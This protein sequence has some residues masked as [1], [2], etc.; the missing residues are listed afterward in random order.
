MASHVRFE[1]FDARAVLARFLL[2]LFGGLFRFVVIEDDVRAGLREQFDCRS[3][4]SPRTP[5][6]E[7]R[8][9]SQ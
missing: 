9:A 5:G 2:H 7:R 3:A 8:L 6:D 4:N 1:R